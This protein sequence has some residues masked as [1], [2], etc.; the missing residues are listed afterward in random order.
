MSLKN[1][2]IHMLYA[3]LYAG[4]SKCMGREL[5]SIIFSLFSLKFQIEGSVF[6]SNSRSQLNKL[7]QSFV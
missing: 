1:Q 6:R 4:P 3:L 5:N 7:W 2:Q